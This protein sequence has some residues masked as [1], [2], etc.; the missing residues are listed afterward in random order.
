MRREVVMEK[1]VMRTLIFALALIVLVL[2]FGS[3]LKSCR[4]CA[5]EETRF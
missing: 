5:A 2:A 1:I 4:V 3:S